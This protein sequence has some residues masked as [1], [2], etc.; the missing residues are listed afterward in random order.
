MLC[1]TDYANLRLAERKC[2]CMMNND[3]VTDSS[4]GTRQSG[5]TDPVAYKPDI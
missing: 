1:N 3:N 4:V 5:M 2:I